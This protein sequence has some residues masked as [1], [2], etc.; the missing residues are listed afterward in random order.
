MSSVLCSLGAFI[1]LF[2]VGCSRDVEKSSASGSAAPPPPPLAASRVFSLPGPSPRD[3]LFVKPGHWT[4]V[5][6][7]ATSA[8]V[9]FR[10]R[11]EGQWVDDAGAPLGYPPMQFGLRHVRPLTLPKGQLRGVEQFTFT[12]DDE[13][14][15][16]P[17]Y[18]EIHESRLREA[19]GRFR[20]TD[21]VA[22]A[23]PYETRRRVT[24]LRDHQALF[25]VLAA[26]PAEQAFL[27]SFDAVAT[28]HSPSVLPEQ[29]VPY[30]TV[31]AAEA[32]RALLPTSLMGWTT[33]A[34][35]FWDGFDLANL[36]D[37]QR[38]ALLD[39]LHW[40]GVLIV[41]GPGTLDA[42]ACEPLRPWLP[43]EADGVV[44]L[45]AAALA[46]LAA[47]SIDGVQPATLRPWTG[48]RLRPTAAGRIIVGTDDIPLVVERRIGRGRIV[49][50]AFR[51][52][53]RE[54]VEWPSYAGFFST[55]LMRRPPRMWRLHPADL[56]F[57]SAVWDDRQEVFF[58]YDPSRVTGVR[59]LTHGGL[60]GTVQRPLFDAQPPVGAGV[61]AWRDDDELA[62][63]AREAL[64]EAS[65]IF[66][67]SASVVLG[68]IALYVFAVVP[69][70]WS[71]FYALGRT[72]WAWA[73]APV[74]AVVFT[75]VV[76]R[77]AELD[78]GFARS[79]SEVTVVELQP[80]YDRA[81]VT[82]YAVL[83]NS[84]GTAY[85]IGGDDPTMV[86]L[87]TVTTL[88][89]KQRPVERTYELVRRD[90]ETGNSRTTL[91][92]FGVD[93]GN[94][95]LLRAEQML[96]VGGTL[97]AEKL[98]ENRYRLTNGTPWELRDVRLSGPAAGAARDLPPG[99][100]VVVT[101]GD[102]EPPP[103]DEAA[104]RA[105][106]DV[107]PLWRQLQTAAPNEG[108]RLTAWT[109]TPVPGLEIDPSP[110]QRR[111]KTLVVAH[112]RYAADPPP[113]NDVN[114][115]AAVEKAIVKKP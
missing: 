101:L 26:N 80:D 77:T 93:S 98:A 23:S 43:A 21:A 25:V 108:L 69:A 68:L 59:L 71:V 83:Y 58:D 91:V 46:P 75:V 67:P 1:I 12:P 11:L 16:E 42:P 85:E 24:A 8:E 70:N 7:E 2:V 99:G 15:S 102:R 22:F 81:H 3:E 64:R 55:H 105:T 100:S 109:S 76:I 90:D 89:N 62:T 84:L 65:G 33:T 34:Y 115:R 38:Q 31:F 44:E 88:D 73:A 111:Q 5:W 72:E 30:R 39:W 96:P 18:H 82:R 6:L 48:V 78:L 60:Q 61:G 29:D 56:E 20:L 114:T 79:A 41:G 95:G 17:P 107:E 94:I 53:R 113:A 103:P 86:A 66:V 37:A 52:T 45:D 50:A 51:L 54:L 63:L 32:N 9:D 112:L 40:G 4:S 49:A 14:F 10:G 28:P 47:L 104:L 19:N 36:G 74:L 35:V 110:S 27:A 97:Q 106:I 92:G 13:D 87:P 57:A